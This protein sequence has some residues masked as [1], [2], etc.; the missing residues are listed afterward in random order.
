MSNTV[1]LPKILY[2]TQQYRYVGSQFTLTKD[3]C[4]NVH[5]GMVKQ[6]QLG[7]SGVTG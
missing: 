6:V 7:A 1:F 4:I 2:T 3:S 5:S